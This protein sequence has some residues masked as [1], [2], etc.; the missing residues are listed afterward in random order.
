MMKGGSRPRGS[1]PVTLLSRLSTLLP[2]HVSEGQAV[3]GGGQFVSK[4]SAL[5]GKDKCQQSRGGRGG[6][7]TVGDLGGK[8]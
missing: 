6:M 3:Q 8:G 5:S 2:T 7:G 1:S 4:E